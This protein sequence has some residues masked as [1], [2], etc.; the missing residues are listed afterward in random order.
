MENN[1]E[2]KQY[3]I[4]EDI[5]Q[6]KSSEIVNQK[7]LE[8]K[9]ID[10]IV[11]LVNQANNIASE[12]SSVEERKKYDEV[13]NADTY[14]DKTDESSKKAIANY[15]KLK[16]M[17]QSHFWTIG[18]NKAKVGQTQE[19][20]NDIIDAI[21][22]NANATKA[23]FNNQT[24]LADLQKKLYGIGL[25]GIASNRIVIR[26]I[27]LRLENASKE[28]LSE[29]ARQ[30]LE[31]TVYELEKQ[32]KL[33]EKIDDINNEINRKMDELL[34]SQKSF[35]TKSEE[36]FSNAISELEKMYES[37][38]KSLRDDQSSAIFNLKNSFDENIA[39]INEKSDELTKSQEAF[40]SKSKEYFSN[41]LSQIREEA[42]AKVAMMKEGTET[43]MVD[44][45]TKYLE[46]KKQVRIYKI[47]SIIA[48]AG[49]IATVICNIIM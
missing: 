12:N 35:I 7:E 28:E 33:E 34:G 36:Q 29:L 30:E 2:T 14:I 5:E 18:R 37:L 31:N 21:N 9:A 8:T 23:L 32:L 47:V 25:M 4:I 22:N 42:N 48:I 39:H 19:V 44:S 41:A 49:S 11:A 10:T 24:R 1:S 16:G 15:D 20:L 17:K 38:S 13:K 3:E 46:M 45:E 27:K 43:F 26:E 6:T 40:M